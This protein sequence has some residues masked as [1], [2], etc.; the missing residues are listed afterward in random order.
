MFLG[1]LL[2]LSFIARVVSVSEGDTIAVVNAGRTENVRLHGIDCPEPNQPFGS[3]AKKAI[4]DLILGKDVVVEIKGKDR[5]GRTL[6]KVSLN[7]KDIELELVKRGMAWH[8]KRH[9]SEQAL[10]EAEAAAR[11]AGRGLWS[12]K[13]A[14][15]PWDWRRGAGRRG[16]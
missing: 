6:G 11:T 16:R 10:A 12:D 7:G 3:Q 14:I 4:S 13:D 5:Y 8:F 9:S 15:P 2:G 1:V